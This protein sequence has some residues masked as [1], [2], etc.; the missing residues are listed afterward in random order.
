MNDISTGQRHARSEGTPE[1]KSG[2]GRLFLAMFLILAGLYACGQMHRSAGAVLSPVLNQELGFDARELASIMAALFLA[3]GATMIP[4]GIFLDRY[5]PRRCM[6]ALVSIGVLGTALF[7]IAESWIALVVARAFIGM[8]FS[9][10]FMSSMVLFTRWTAPGRLTAWSGRITAVGGCGGLLAT[11]PLAASIEWLGW[12]PTMAGLAVIA[13]LLVVIALRFIKDHPQ[14]HVATADSTETLLQ[15]LGGFLRVLREP[16]VRPILIV[17]LVLYTPMQMT[18]GLWGGPFLLEV[19]GLD[20]ITRGHV[21][22][23]VFACH[24]VAALG[25]GALE[26]LFN[27][28]KWLVVTC[29]S[30]QSVQ[31]LLLGWIGGESLPLAIALMIGIGL[32][33]PVY[34]VSTVHCQSMFPRAL[35]GRAV[36]TVT[37]LSVCGVFL[38]QTTSSFVVRAFADPGLI[39]SDA[40][41]R[42]V[43]MAISAVFVLVALIYTRTSDKPPEAR[44]P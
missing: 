38:T 23:V 41:Y 8:G 29:A 20:A 27:S 2:E 36:A 4:Y 1:R 43:F 25:F 7:A 18:V 39:G 3:A 21:L 44:V 33:A 22:F 14:S 34:L 12:R 35:T 17:S 9:A 19:H 42:A 28:R 15:S 40:A 10:V 37:A 16:A 11:T 13:G 26:R 5:G 24:L 30:L 32:L 6:T 31:F